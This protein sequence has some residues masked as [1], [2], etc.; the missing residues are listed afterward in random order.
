M[1]D[2][3][4][5]ISDSASGS[6]MDEETGLTKRERQ[7]KKR[8]RDQLDVRIGGGQRVGQEAGRG[9]REGDHIPITKQ[10][11]RIADRDV[12]KKLLVNSLLILLWYFFSLAISLVGVISIIYL[13]STPRKR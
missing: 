8:Q 11:A 4:S 3:R 12:I 13:H 10:E 7:Q 2:V 6:E 9:E 5:D 1:T